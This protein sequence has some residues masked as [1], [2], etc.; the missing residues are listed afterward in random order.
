M[1]L[2]AVAALSSPCVPESFRESYEAWPYLFAVLAII[3]MHFMDFAVAEYM[4]TVLGEAKVCNETEMAEEGKKEHKH[5]HEG[6]SH[7]GLMLD[8]RIQKTISA[9]LLEF[10]VTV[11]SIFIGLTVGVADNDTIKAL[12]V[13]IVFHQLFE[14]LALGSRVAEANLPG[15]KF[16]EIMHISVFSVSAPLGIAIGVG[17]ISTL[18]TNGSDF[19]MVSGTFEAICAGILIYIGAQ[20]L[21]QDFPE[22]LE[23][24]CAG[25]PRAFLRKM[26]MFAGLW[27]GVAIMAL[28]GKWF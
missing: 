20:L 2:P 5:K 16:A 8:P 10:G 15:G 6:H 12:L 4:R 3:V 23:T 22:D 9:Y 21:L 26:G 24:H 11:H 18:N 17:V 13:A 28:I 25:K 1:L 27:F 14:G 19:L 7:G